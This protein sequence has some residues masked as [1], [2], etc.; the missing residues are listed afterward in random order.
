M[1][2]NPI[3]PNHY[4]RFRIQPL[5]FIQANK[6]GFAVGN[7]IKYVC[8]YDAK[9]GLE[10]LRKARSYLDRLIKDEEANVPKPV[11]PVP[12][13]PPLGVHTEGS[14]DCLCLR[15]I[16]ARSRPRPMLPRHPEGVAGGAAALD[17]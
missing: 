9:N 14:K 17:F 11:N 12:A 1:T 16:T 7:V 3:S 8:R 13:P 10:D 5:D 2:D 6:L 15:C 4:A